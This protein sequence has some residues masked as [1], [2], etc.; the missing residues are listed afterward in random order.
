MRFAGSQDSSSLGSCFLILHPPSHPGFF[1]QHPLRL[2]ARS[3]LSPDSHP[4]RT[5]AHASHPHSTPTRLAHGPPQ[6]RIRSHALC[7]PNLS[8]QGCL[9][10]PVAS[11]SSVHPG[12][13]GW[14]GPGQ[15]SAYL[16]SLRHLAPHC[17][18]PAQIPIVSRTLHIY[19]L[20]LTT[21]GSGRS[22]AGP[23]LG[24]A[25]PPPRW[26]PGPRARPGVSEPLRGS[27]PLICSTSVSPGSLLV[28]P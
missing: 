8:P 18:W 24:W 28:R 10:S 12:R 19:W 16:G 23:E 22:W 11:F 14:S 21:T 17:A 9:R 13:P 2:P 3:R 1:S 6:N 4:A 20:V 26:L 15:V 27:F 25:L 7:L 5:R